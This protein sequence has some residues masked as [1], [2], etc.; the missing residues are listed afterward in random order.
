MSDKMPDRR[1]GTVSHRL[2]DELPV[3]MLTCMSNN[4][5]KRVPE[6]KSTDKVSPRNVR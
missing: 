5:S 3:A 1:P 4:M 6:K 2:P